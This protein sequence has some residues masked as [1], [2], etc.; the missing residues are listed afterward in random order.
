V[1]AKGCAYLIEAFQ[2]IARCIPG[3]E[4]IVIGDGPL[5]GALEALARK[6]AVRMEFLGAVTQ[7]IVK[8]HLDEARVLCLPSITASNGGF[9]AFGMVLLEAQACGVPVVTSAR[10][11]REGVSEG[12]T[13]FTF[14]EKDVRTLVRQVCEILGN[15]ELASRMSRTGPGYVRQ[16]FDIIKCTKTIEDFYDEI[17]SA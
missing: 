12:V 15:D 8:Q 10:A 1:E 7:D 5:R 13:G 11:G 17:L 2:E 6:L 16:H 3:A 14:P 4:L 9:E